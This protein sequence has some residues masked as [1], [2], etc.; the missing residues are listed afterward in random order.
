MKMK[1]EPKIYLCTLPCIFD[2]NGVV[3]QGEMGQRIDLYSEIIVQ[4]AEEYR[5]SLIDMNVES[6]KHFDWYS[7]DHLHFSNKGAKAV[8]NYIKEFIT[9]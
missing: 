9:D 1:S 6:K 5:L 8:A 2:E 3:L 4:I 7:E